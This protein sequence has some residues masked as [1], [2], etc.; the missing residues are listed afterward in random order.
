MPSWYINTD[1][2]KTV[3]EQQLADPDFNKPAQVDIIIGAGHYDDLMVGNNRL[4]EPNFSV[5]YTLSIRLELGNSQQQRLRR[6]RL[7][8]VLHRLQKQ[9]DLYRRYNE[10]IQ[11]IINQGHMEEVPAKKML[12]PIEKNYYPSH[13]CV[14]K[15]SSTTTKLRLVFDGSA[16]TTSKISLNDGLMVGTKIQKGLF[17]ILILFRIYPVACSADIAKS[18]DKCNWTPKIKTVINYFARNRTQQI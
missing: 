9:T 5:T 6:R 17:S 11:E 15:D 10:F 7:R 1:N 3:K 4:R 13:H 12:L 16:T 8:N 2:W 14:F 18:T